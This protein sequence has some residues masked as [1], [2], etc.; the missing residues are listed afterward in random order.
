M[1][2]RYVV[3][4]L[5]VKFTEGQ[6]LNLLVYQ[7]YNAPPDADYDG[8]NFV[9]PHKP[10]LK[11]YVLQSHELPITIH[12]LLLTGTSALRYAFS[13]VDPEQSAAA[14]AYAPGPA[15]SKTHRGSGSSAS[16]GAVMYCLNAPLW[17]FGKFVC[18]GQDSGTL[19][20]Q[21]AQAPHVEAR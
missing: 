16:H 19:R 20:R 9:T 14:Y 18:A 6:D 11:R 12:Y 13:A 8:P 3:G 1:D 10:A 2:V 17:C 15:P 4:H 5:Q 7:F 21:Y